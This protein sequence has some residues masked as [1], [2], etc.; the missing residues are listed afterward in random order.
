MKNARKE[1]MLHLLFRLGG[2]V[3]SSTSV[4][5]PCLVG[6]CCRHDNYGSPDR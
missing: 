4:A 1:A 5:L 6:A 2:I 3:L